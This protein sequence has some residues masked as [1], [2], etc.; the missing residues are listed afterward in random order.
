MDPGKNETEQSSEL[1]RAF[2]MWKKESALSAIIPY[3][4]LKSEQYRYRRHYDLMRIKLMGKRNMYIC[5]WCVRVCV[6]RFRKKL[7]CR[8]NVTLQQSLIYLRDCHEAHVPI[9]GYECVVCELFHCIHM[10]D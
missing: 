2:I 5:T 1:R 9:F 4:G 7:F 3:G 6:R 10:T 8:F